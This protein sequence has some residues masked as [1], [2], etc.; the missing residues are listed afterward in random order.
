MFKEPQLVEG[1]QDVYSRKI[2]VV[3]PKECL[4]A[5]LI[6]VEPRLER[7]SEALHRPAVYLTPEVPFEESLEGWAP[8]L[9]RIIRR[10]FLEQYRAEGSDDLPA[11]E[12]P[13]DAFTSDDEIAKCF[14][15]WWTIREADDYHEFIDR[16][17]ITE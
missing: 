11:V 13:D 5:H 7:F 2:F 6:G 14:D 15:Q 4:V 12:I 3:A 16:A 1:R 9:K 17:W 10:K 8:G